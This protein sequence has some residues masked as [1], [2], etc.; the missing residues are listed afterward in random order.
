[1]VKELHHFIGGKKVMGKSGRF[2]PVYNPTTG[3]EAAK[4]PLAS[5]AEV[6]AAIADSQGAFAG[7]S[8]TS[9]LVR[10]R[11]M[12]KFKALVEK[13]IDEIALLISNEHGKVLADAKGSIQRGLEV[14]EF[15]CGIPH[16]LKGDYSDSVSAGIDVYSMRQALGVVAGITPFNFP[17]MI[18]MWMASVAI[19]CGNT[20]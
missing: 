14:V 4:S 7:W 9:P 1:M 17:A 18:P 2:G 12:F 15:A 3:E 6:E 19:A 10:A 5:R 11:V 20:F 13:H 8:G 16:L